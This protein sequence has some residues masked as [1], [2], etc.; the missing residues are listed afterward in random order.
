MSEPEKG[1]LLTWVT[2]MTVV[3]IIGAQLS[4]SKRSIHAATPDSYRAPATADI[5]RSIGKAYRS[6]DVVTG[7]TLA[8]SITEESVR[9]QAIDLLRFRDARTALENHDLDTTYRLASELPASLKRSLLLAGIASQQTAAGEKGAAE[10]SLGRALAECGELSPPVRIRFLTVVAR[11]SLANDAQ[12]GESVLRQAVLAYRMARKG[13]VP[14]LGGR[15]GREGGT[16]AGFYEVVRSGSIASQVFPLHVPGV[17]AGHLG[18]L[19][20]DHYP[21]KGG[22]Q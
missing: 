8:E 4:I 5:L 14:G 15:S 19:T 1:I 13:N 6:G 22:G 2:A 7:K 20:L 9:N 11:L 12:A 18:E 10:M 17:P 21:V 16:H 3:S